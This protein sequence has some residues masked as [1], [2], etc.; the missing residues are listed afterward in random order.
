[1]EPF[2]SLQRVE[3]EPATFLS[4]RGEI[5]AVFDERTQDSG[6]VSYGVEVDGQQY[7]VKTAGRPDDNTSY[8]DHTGRV[9]L[10]RNAVKLA[11]S[12]DHRT[13]PNL[14]QVVE[15]SWGPMLVYDWAEGELV[16]SRLERVRSLTVSEV[17]HLVTEVYDLH[18]EL[19]SLGWIANDFYDGAMIYDF[20]SRRVHVID[21]D[22][23]HMGSFTNS[24][25]RMAG[26][27]RF[28]APE[29]FELGAT[30]DERTT[31]FTMGRTAAVLMSD[32]SLE[33]EPFRGSDRQYEV[34]VR[35]CAEDP[36]DRFQTVAEMYAA[37]V[38]VQDH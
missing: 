6:N 25:G 4:Q 30:I 28:M 21:L 5:F 33:R 24:M 29:E 38:G 37:W 31:V 3:S 16:R 32:N 7:F 27:S 8:L 22:S 23:Y 12:S 17:G 34:I 18:R 9:S 2:P 19:A 36:D 20:R 1:M 11:E 10:L 14:H 15:T 13:L 35:S 26:S